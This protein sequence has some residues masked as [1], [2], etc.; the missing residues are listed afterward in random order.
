ML[1]GFPRVVTC[2][3]PGIAHGTTIGEAAAKEKGPVMGADYAN[4]SGVA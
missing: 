4:E 1:I 2:A 3:K